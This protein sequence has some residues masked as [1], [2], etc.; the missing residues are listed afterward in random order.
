MIGV[1]N[2]YLKNSYD[3]YDHYD[4]TSK[5]KASASHSPVIVVIASNEF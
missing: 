4:A 1:I 3:C 2:I 5:F